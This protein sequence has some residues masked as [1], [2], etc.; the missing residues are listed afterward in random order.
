VRSA[1]V[2]CVPVRQGRCGLLVGIATLLAIGGSGFLAQGSAALPSECSEGARKI[3]TCTYVSGSNPFT[4]PPHVKSI[5]VVAV[6][7]VGGASSRGDP[8]GRAGRVEGDLKIGRQ[9][10]LYALVGGNAAG[11]AAGANGGGRGHDYVLGGA[12]HHSSGGGGGASDLRTSADD[13]STRVLVAG[14]GGGAGGEG[15]EVDNA[16]VPISGG[17][18]LPGGVGGDAGAGNGSNGQ[19]NLCF[20]AGPPPDF[21]LFPGGAGGLG[22]AAPS[23]IGTDGGAVIGT[24]TSQC[25]PVIEGGPGGGGGGGLLGG[26]GGAS[27]IGAAGGGGG[28]GSNLVPPRGSAS[29][30]TTGIPLVQI[31]YRRHGRG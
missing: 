22:G 12:F 18:V 30:D 10:T 1:R 8:G 27:A 5:H 24:N 25:H 17:A 2:K 26:G 23:G 15:I 11:A 28:G 4:V 7:G 19:E 13:V 16:G 21:L 20:I 9:Q 14:G 29:I 31:S 3:V 6:G